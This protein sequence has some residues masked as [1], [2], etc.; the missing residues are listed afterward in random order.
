M[1]IDGETKA[2]KDSLGDLD[3]G[4]PMSQGQSQSLQ[5]LRDF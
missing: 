3:P 4:H 5:P 2:L 1:F